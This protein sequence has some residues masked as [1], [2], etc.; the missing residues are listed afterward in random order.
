MAADY[1]AI[2]DTGN[3]KLT[4]CVQYRVRIILEIGL[5]VY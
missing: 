5:Y 2:Y 3:H 4:P 1:A